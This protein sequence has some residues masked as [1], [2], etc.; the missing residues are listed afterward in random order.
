MITFSEFKD[1]EAGCGNVGEST[2][3][4][5]SLLAQYLPAPVQITWKDQAKQTEVIM[6]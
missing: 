2:S 6:D 1:T 5:V 3:V 4:S